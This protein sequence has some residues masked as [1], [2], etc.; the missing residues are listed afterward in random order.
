MKT[1]EYVKYIQIKHKDLKKIRLKMYTEQ[2]GI[3]PILKE[4]FP[5][6]DFCIDHKHKTKKE[7]IGK[8]DAGLIRG[9][10]HRQVNSFEGKV[11]NSYKRYGLDKFDIS[12]SD[13]LRN[14]A[15]YLEQQSTNLI[16]PNE[17]PKR[18]ILTKSSYNKLK[19]LWELDIT[20]KPKL[21]EY[22]I[23]EHKNIQTFT[24]IFEKLYKRYNIK[25]EFYK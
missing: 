2:N 3:C 6:Q 14:L 5:I 16:H 13:I 24:K 10:I 18:K 4:T 11:T 9:C 21:P 1:K 19:K 20:R 8:N 22:R 7:E 17:Q 15:D 12:L 25:P 23:K